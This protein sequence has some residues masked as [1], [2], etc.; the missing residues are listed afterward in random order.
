MDLSTLFLELSGTP[1]RFVFFKK[2][3]AI[4]IPT[5]Q[6]RKK[7]KKVYC[8][9]TLGPG[10]S[11]LPYYCTLPVCVPAVLGGLTV[12]HLGSLTGANWVSFDFNVSYSS[13][14]GYSLIN[15]S[16]FKKKWR[17]N[18]KKKNR[19]RQSNSKET[20]RWRHGSQTG[21]SPHGPPGQASHIMGS[22]WCVYLGTQSCV[23][24]LSLSHLWGV[25][26]YTGQGRGGWM[27]ELMVSG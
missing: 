20:C 15:T 25:L 4:I 17:H 2:C 27:V 6:V 13:C 11:G 3:I 7:R 10:A 24:C 26:Y 1:W 23:C 16:K 9:S 21:E 22:R 8:G 12:W 14:W 5:I 19:S 18:N